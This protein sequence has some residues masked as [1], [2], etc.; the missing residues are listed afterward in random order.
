MNMLLSK[1]LRTGVMGG[2]LCLFYLILASFVFADDAG[3]AV[4]FKWPDGFKLHNGTVRFQVQS[5]PAVGSDGTIYVGAVKVPQLFQSEDK[6]TEARLYAINPEGSFKWGNGGYIVLPGLPSSSAGDLMVVSPSVAQDGTI[7]IAA[8]NA[9]TTDNSSPSAGSV[10]KLYAVNPDGTLKWANGVL[11]EGANGITAYADPLSSEYGGPGYAS[12]IDADGNV[13]LTAYEH[14]DV[15]E[16]TT[17]AWLYSF[18]PEGGQRW[19]K[20]LD[21]SSYPGLS[22][23]LDQDGIVYVGGYN[24]TTVTNATGG[25]TGY[26]GKVWLYAFNNDGT[27]KYKTLLPGGANELRSSPALGKD[28][29]YITALKKGRGTKTEDLGEGVMYSSSVDTAQV[30]LYAV[31]AGDGTLKWADGFL[32]S[33]DNVDGVV[34]WDSYDEY[35]TPII[36]A[37]GDIY[38]ALSRNQIPSSRLYAVKDMSTFGDAKWENPCT[39]VNATFVSSPTISRDGD[40]YVGAND[41]EWDKVYVI[42]KE[43]GNEEEV[44]RLPKNATLHA[45]SRSP[46]LVRSSMF[47]GSDGTLY[48]GAFDNDLQYNKIFHLWG[49]EGVATGLANATWPRIF[50]TNANAGNMTPLSGGTEPGGDEPGEEPGGE[51]P[52]GDE[53]DGD[54]PG[55]TTPDTDDITW[56]L[57]GP[58]GVDVPGGEYVEALSAPAVGSDGTLYITATNAT[59]S[60]GK[61]DKIL[62]TA[63]KP[64]DGSVPWTAELGGLGEYGIQVSSPVIASDGSLYFVGQNGSQVNVYGVDSEGSPLAQWGAEGVTLPGLVRIVDF[65]TS[66][67]MPTAPGF[68]APTL[69][70]GGLTLYVAG[71]KKAAVEG[72]PDEAWMY[73]IDVITGTVKWD[74]AME[75]ASYVGFSPAVDSADTVYVAAY[76]ATA[77]IKDGYDTV[78]YNGKAWLYSFDALGE[79]TALELT[80]GTAGATEVRSS[81]VIGPDGTVYV[82][83]HK[84]TAIP[85]IKS[86][87]TSYK[88]SAETYLY[89][90]KPDLS[91]FKWS[92]PAPVG[93]G[94]VYPGLAFGNGNIYV[95]CGGSFDYNDFAKLYAVKVEDGSLVW[96]EPAD[97]GGKQGVSSPVVDSKGAIYVATTEHLYVIQSNGSELERMEPPNATEVTDN[98]LLNSSPLATGSNDTLYVVTKQTDASYVDHVRIYGIQRGSGTGDEPG[99]D[100]PGGDEPGG[101]DNVWANGIMLPGEGDVE[102]DAFL[103]AVGADGTVYFTTTN[104]TWSSSDSRLYGVKK[105]GSMKW[106]EGVV[107]P[108]VKWLSSSPAVG[109]DG[110]V[111]VGGV[112]KRK[113]HKKDE[114]GTAMFNE[115][116]SPVLVDV[117]QAT[118]YAI[119]SDGSM[120]WSTGVELTGAK[121]VGYAPAIG[122]D[123]TIYVGGFTHKEVQVGEDPITGVPEYQDQ[124]KAW[125]YA[126][127]PEGTLKWH[128]ALEHAGAIDSAPAIDSSGNV[129]IGA[130]RPL[131]KINGRTKFGK[132]IKEDISEAWM[133]AFGPDGTKKWQTELDEVGHIYSSPAIGTNGKVYIAG[134]KRAYKNYLD[135]DKYALKY[136]KEAW[137]Y[138]LASDGSIV[139]KKEL[140]YDPPADKTLDIAERAFP[141]IVHIYSA[142]VVGTDGTIYLGHTWQENATN[143]KSRGYLQ[144]FTSEGVSKWQTRLEGTAFSPA[145]IIAADGVIYM[146][147]NTK[148][149][150]AIGLDG[151]ILWSKGTQDIPDG[152]NHYEITPMVSSL[153]LTEG[154]IFAA[155]QSIH[156]GTYTDGVFLFGLPTNSTGLAD[157]PWPKMLKDNANTGASTTTGGGD[158]PGGDSSVWANGIMLP[159]E[160]NVEINAFP[161]AIGAD[162]TVYFATTNGTWLSSDSRLY[163][164]KKDGSMK[165]AEGIVIPGVKWLS[166]APAIGSDG[167]VYVGGVTKRKTHKKDEN[168]TAMFNEDGSPVLVDVDQATLY[169]LASDGSMKWSAG[170][171]LTGAKS[172]GYAPAIG[173]DGTI[174]VGGY[175]HIE[176][177]VGEDPI[178][179]V[180]E[181]QDQSKAW[182]YAVAPEGTLKWHKPLEHAGAIDSAPAI[183]S[184]GNVYIGAYRP[185]V[186]ING[187]T[188]F[189][190]DI[191]EDISEAWMYA[192]GPDGA[193]K[194]Q[195]RL[196]EVGHLYSSPAIGTNGVIYLAGQKRAYKNYLNYDRTALK[197]GKEAWLYALASDGSIT[198]K[199]ELAYAPPVDKTL[200]IAERAFPAIVNIYSAPVVGAD[201]TIYLGHTWR[202]NATDF[203]TRGYVQAFTPEGVS[204]WQTA[205]EG[206]AF[207]PAPIIAAD[208]IVYMGSNTKG[209]YAIGNGGEILWSEGPQNIPDGENTYQITPV[210]SSLA[211]TNGMLFAAGQSLH[212]GTYTDGVF[213]FGLPTNSTGLA[214]SPWPKMLKDNANTGASTT[215]GGGDEP[216]GDEPGGDTPVTLPVMAHAAQATGVTVTLNPDETNAAKRT[217][218][219]LKTTYGLERFHPS[220]DVITY[221]AGVEPTGSVAVFRFNAT[222]VQGS[223]SGLTLVHCN[224]NPKSSKA[225]VYADAPVTNAA[226]TWWMENEQGSYLP[227]TTVLTLGVKYFVCFTSKDSSLDWDNDAVDGTLAGQVVLGVQAEEPKVVAE[228]VEGQATPPATITSSSV[229]EKTK[230]AL[231]AAYTEPEGKPLSTLKQITPLVSFN[232]T[233]TSVGKVGVFSIPFNTLNATQA[234][235]LLV[236]KFND[237]TKKVLTYKKGDYAAKAVSNEGGKWWVAKTDGTYLPGNTPISYAT[238]YKLYFTVQDGG[239]FDEDGTKNGK[240]VDPV[241]VGL[242]AVPAGGA[243]VPGGTTSNSGGSGGCSLNPGATLGLEW[244]LFAFPALPWMRRR[245]SK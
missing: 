92:H 4:T 185:L 62:L 30:Y 66:Y 127:A 170:V 128:Q 58:I 29:V 158:E 85:V 180:P 80:D 159:G 162:G 142:P 69:S 131:E 152:E 154:M 55:A 28:A 56:T 165:W 74:K 184:S 167:T 156:T 196:D 65:S 8:S 189:H 68:F 195:T 218:G 244:L 197:Y 161:P 239:K 57:T 44:Q 207:S 193:R 71:Y 228:P 173:T 144:A 157:S 95:A 229:E 238:S 27:Q 106:A 215:T 108:G 220:T 1:G 227:A 176:V 166:S 13:Y 81:P 102:I 50:G 24:S 25:V 190:K 118:L 48:V 39:F 87:G 172:V 90:V 104:G 187:Q 186:K 216:G 232:A 46:V 36:D 64:D 200:D 179:G 63:I 141:A 70:S 234:K 99:G 34:E 114:N 145:P 134:Q 107:I 214:D 94:T 205:L 231:Q 230:E 72:D 76:N 209:I 150:Y 5:T 219:Y 222:T 237:T 2:L 33:Q 6:V 130:Y 11:L 177:K 43:N 240:I 224:D 116:G 103:S 18:T 202:Q 242:P 15:E 199:K 54:E 38:I 121:S 178:T 7:Y 88:E 146:G 120:K 124:S 241:A 42:N 169:A 98:R 143:F 101:D 60:F 122:A 223:V 113:T 194:W 181:Y 235:D 51:E 77:E 147:S 53:P 208:G 126:V 133:Y 115:D 175:S 140:S 82:L 79:A 67:N 243:V 225:F 26:N 86:W 3:S 191:K 100:E 171:D 163:A 226:G 155:G 97:L 221:E 59:S 21:G 109:S 160:G 22:P 41:G 125:L 139:W 17:R 151:E 78:G 204:K 19:K 23:T 14:L 149:V 213:L 233:V 110:T 83:G 49:V 112:A 132:D 91:G 40:I 236:I 138:A 188:K 217:K 84:K 31:K 52:S 12:A 20:A 153:A 16:E 245:M 117:D 61:K 135:D 164:V 35:S 183:D 111:Y 136:G 210:V 174:Y 119:T 123:G 212:T 93:N 105:D 37:A 198:W 10:V 73:A 168:G 203:N 129:Y 148:G 211:V 206:T 182:L 201:G 192:F 75:G 89:A 137:L 45:G 32:L 9:T 96:A 47:I